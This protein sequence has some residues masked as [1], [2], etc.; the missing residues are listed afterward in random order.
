MN[1]RNSK[2]KKKPKQV[3]VFWCDGCVSM[4]RSLFTRELRDSL[5]TVG[6]LGSHKTINKVVILEL[7]PL[8]L[9]I[10]HT[11]GSLGARNE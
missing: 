4:S 8:L 9:F 1:F 10:L 3:G 7:I 5:T 6:G 11:K 2:K